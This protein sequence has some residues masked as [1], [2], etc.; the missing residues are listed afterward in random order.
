MHFGEAVAIPHKP[1]VSQGT[2]ELSAARS[3]FLRSRAKAKSD[4][5]WVL[6][7]TAFAVLATIAASVKTHKVG[8]QRFRDTLRD[9]H[10]ILQQDIVVTWVHLK[11][12][13]GP[14][15]TLTPNPNPDPN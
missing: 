15:L 2:S 9:Y 7:R 1:Y 6:A 3:E 8:R 5:S 11:L 4:L 13:C 10:C 14:T 12:E